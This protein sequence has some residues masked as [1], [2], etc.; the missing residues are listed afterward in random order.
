MKYTD[1]KE[2]WD[3]LTTMY[4]ASDAGSDLYVIES[5][6][7]YKMVDNRSIVEQ[8]HEIHCIIKELDHF[9]IVLPDRFVAGCII[10]NFS[11]I[12]RNFATSLKHKRQEISIENMIVSLDVKEKARAKV[13]SSKG[14]EGHSS[15]NMV[16]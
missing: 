5:F 4:G 12:W 10:A 13:T 9:K 15:A 16:Q 1:G 7:D 11:S 6:H 2:L 3:A 14:G 8:A